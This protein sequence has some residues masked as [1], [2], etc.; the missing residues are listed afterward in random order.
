MDAL[1]VYASFGIV[2]ALGLG[3]FVGRIMDLQWRTKKLRNL[4][5]RDYG[6]PCK[7]FAIEPSGFRAYLLIELLE[8]WYRTY[9]YE[10]TGKV[11][12]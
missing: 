11:N 7:S 8:D 10:R 5:K 6:K 2:I 12:K 4:L 9:A 1:I 3:W